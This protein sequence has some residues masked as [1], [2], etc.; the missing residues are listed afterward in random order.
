MPMRGKSARHKMR[1]LPL[2]AATYFMVSGGP[3]GIEDILGGAGF[4]RAIILLL[5]L[6]LVWS[7]PT[8]LMIGELAAAIP[9][10]GGFYVWV[11]RAMG[12]F[13]GY[14]ESWLSLSAS[15]FDM[16][17]YPSM[18]VLYLGKF[19]PALGDGWKG[20]AGSLAV[21]V[22]CCLWNL[23]GAP[24]VGEDSV[25]LGA[26]LLAPFAVFVVLGLWRGFT[27]HPAIAW[28]RP[29]SDQALSTAFLVALWNYMGWDNASTVAREVEDPQRTYPRAM[30]AATVLTTITY[31][32]PLAAM[33]FAG[34]SAGSFS[35][36]DW[37]TAARQVGGP[38]LGMAV[39]AGG[40]ITGVGMFNALVMSYTRLPM[41]MAEDGMLPRA[42]AL[43]NTRGVP[44]VSV[45]FCGLAWALALK[46]PFERLISIDLILYGTS[47]L[48]EFVALVVLRLREPELKRPFKAGG[49]GFACLLG[50]GPAALI[51][52][53]LY[54]SRAEK[55]IGSV[56]A[57]AFAAAVG[58]AGPV[59]YWLTAMV[60]ARRPVADPAL[61]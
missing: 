35:T 39:I 57:L 21:V 17:L 4:L 48:I 24:E 32:L 43:R 54:V 60:T 33:A 49:F 55:V 12:P 3:Y 23:R 37:T 31:I 59:L 51:G 58:L 40:C 19:N 9:A 36:G 22:L 26:L 29:A 6:P 5:A 47:L 13:W 11:R 16:A 15:I 61:D 2:V 38:L 25:G 20:Y 52:Y 1:L 8:A 10:E 44:W 45:L 14:Q 30:I 27:H 56:S 53:A 7:L 18:F 50:A 46:L 34:L 42:L 41:A 28:G